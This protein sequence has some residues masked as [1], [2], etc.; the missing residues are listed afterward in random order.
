MIVY[1]APRLDT[2]QV[3]LQLGDVQLSPQPYNLFICSAQLPTSGAF[4]AVNAVHS[5]SRSRHLP[6]ILSHVVL[7]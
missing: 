5:V 7:R 1:V 4:E 6:F 3:S 2:T